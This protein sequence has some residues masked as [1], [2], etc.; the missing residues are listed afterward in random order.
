MPS[1]ELTIRPYRGRYQRSALLVG[2]GLTI[3][4]G[5]SAVGSI[6]FIVPAFFDGCKAVATAVMCVHGWKL[7]QATVEGEQQPRSALEQVTGIARQM[8]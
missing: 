6:I 5:F 4:Y 7:Y 2:T 8:F 1:G 3:F